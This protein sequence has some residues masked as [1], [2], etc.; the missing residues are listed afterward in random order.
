MER[1]ANERSVRRARI[2]VVP[3]KR[4]AIRLFVNYVTIARSRNVLLAPYGPLCID[5]K[6]DESWKSDNA[7]GNDNI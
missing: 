2:C 1:S 5:F 4:I 6:A 7:N 3:S